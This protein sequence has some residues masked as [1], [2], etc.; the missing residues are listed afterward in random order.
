M[1]NSV[2]TRAVYIVDADTAVKQGLAR[3]V[4]SAGLESRP[5]DSIDAFLGQAPGAHAACALLDVSDPRLREPALRSRVRA[6]AEA[7]PI[8]ALSARDDP[9]TRRTARELGAQAFFRKPVD[10]AALLD[11]IDWVMRAEAH[12]GAP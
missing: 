10:A 11:S 9:A 6:G 3:L 1:S 5:C 8:I 12:V 4:D 2:L 7:I